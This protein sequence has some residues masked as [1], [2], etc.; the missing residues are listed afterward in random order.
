MLVC[1][2]SDGRS[3]MLCSFKN[4]L[5][6]ISLAID[7][8]LKSHRNLIR[9]FYFKAAKIRWRGIMHAIHGDRNINAREKYSCEPFLLDC[10]RA[11]CPYQEATQD[12]QI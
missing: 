9:K 11:K 7:D 5:L 10:S 1:S 4:L 12:S 3:R 6:W 8:V 2:F